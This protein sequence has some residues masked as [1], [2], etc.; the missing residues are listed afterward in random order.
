[1]VTCPLGFE[2]SGGGVVVVVVVVVVLVVVVAVAV[3]PVVVVPVEPESDPADGFVSGASC[4][5][6]PT[7]RFAS[8]C[9]VRAALGRNLL[10]LFA[11]MSRCVTTVAIC[12]AAQL[13]R[14]PAAPGAAAAV[15]AAMAT[16]AAIVTRR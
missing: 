15:T 14:R 3:V 12:G 10:T 1:M 9:R 6:R 4:C 11:S 5:F 8:V 13:G 7:P 2:T 16:M